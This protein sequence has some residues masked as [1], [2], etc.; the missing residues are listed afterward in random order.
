MIWEAARNSPRT[1]MREVKI[2]L[3][4]R[5][6]EFS[7]SK[8]NGFVMTSGKYFNQREFFLSFLNISRTNRFF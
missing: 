6:K 2:Y 8:I 3:L 1:N 7:Q 4:K 5:R